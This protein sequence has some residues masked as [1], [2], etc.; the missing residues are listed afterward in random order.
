M[1]A[2]GRRWQRCSSC[3]CRLMSASGQRPC[4][5][6]HGRG[7]HLPGRSTSIRA[8][9]RTAWVQESACWAVA[10]ERWARRAP[11][12]SRKGLFQP[13]VRYLT[14]LDLAPAPSGTSWG[15]EPRSWTPRP[16]LSR[17]AAA[18]RRPTAMPP[19]PQMYGSSVRIDREELPQH[20]HSVASTVGAP[21]CCGCWTRDWRAPSL[22]QV[23]TITV[24]NCVMAGAPASASRTPL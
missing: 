4:C 10:V 17:P 15:H 11:T 7:H 9:W 5:P 12:T 24:L 18:C 21:S 8:L 2:A 14:H 13:F 3:G 23:G 16:D 6:S 1:A 20:P 22:P 19:R